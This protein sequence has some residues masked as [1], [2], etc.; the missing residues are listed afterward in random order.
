MPEL[1]AVLLMSMG[2][3]LG[4]K[5][6][7]RI[8]VTLVYLCNIFYGM[9]VLVNLLGCLWLFTARCEGLENSWLTNVGECTAQPPHSSLPD[10]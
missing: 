2:G 1:Q 7:G 9:A 4:R 5:L 10:I 6:L 8:P 3:R